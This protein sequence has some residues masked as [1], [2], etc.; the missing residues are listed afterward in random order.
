MVTTAGVWDQN[1][2]IARIVPDEPD[3]DDSDPCIGPMDE[4]GNFTSYLTPTPDA[5]DTIV[6]Y[7][8]MVPDL[9]LQ[10]GNIRWYSDKKLLNLVHTGNE[11]TY[12]TYRNRG[13]YLLRNP[14]II[15][16]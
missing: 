5:K 15:G 8:Q 11:F 2:P 6:L 14:N 13:L 4:Y 16:L 9:M 3:G 10:V 12:R 7:G 1:H